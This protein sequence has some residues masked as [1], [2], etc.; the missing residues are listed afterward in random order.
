[1]KKHLFF[2]GIF[3]VIAAAPAMAEMPFTGFIGLNLG[4]TQTV[5]ADSLDKDY[6]PAFHGKFGAEGGIKFGNTENI[7]NI[8]A[9]AFY[10]K[11]LARDMDRAGID[12]INEVYEEIYGEPLG[13]DSI[14]V[15]Y[16]AFGA[17]IDNYVRVHSDDGSSIYLIAGAGAANLTR[18]MTLK[19]IYAS[20]D[21]K[22]DS[23]VFLLKL[24]GIYNFS[25]HLGLTLGARIMFPDGY[26]LVN[27]EVGFRYTF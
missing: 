5:F 2:A 9:T 7:Y 8:G 3:S 25:E 17:T 20:H 13:L 16:S 1:M 27:Y 4:A 18:T 11:T 12:F 15:G 19:S 21:E 6:M 24:G 23:T 14:S 10:D 26:T 22:E